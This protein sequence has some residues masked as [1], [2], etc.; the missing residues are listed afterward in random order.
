[1]RPLEWRRIG[2]GW[3]PSL[4][5]AWSLE[6]EVGRFLHQLRQLS[7]CAF[8]L[9]REDSDVLLSQTLRTVG[10][11]WICCFKLSRFVPFCPNLSFW[12][13]R[14]RFSLR[15]GTTWDRTGQTGTTDFFRSSSSTGFLFFGTTCPPP[16]PYARELLSSACWNALLQPKPAP[17]RSSAGAISRWR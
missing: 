14:G 16:P 4:C 2:R 8:G 15:F 5:R 12:R 6:P 1:M 10:L 13:P 3:H 7:R 17:G 11:Q 9:S